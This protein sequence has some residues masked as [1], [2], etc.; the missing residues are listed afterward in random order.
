MKKFT[1]SRLRTKFTISSLTIIVLLGTFW[2]GDTLHGQ[3]YN[4]FTPHST[5]RVDFSALN[6][7]YALMK[8]NF[9][10]KIDAKSALE[11]ATHYPVPAVIEQSFQALWEKQRD[12]LLASL[13]ARRVERT[14]NLEKSL[15]ELAEKEVNKL[16]TVMLELQRSIQDELER[17]DGPQMLLDLGGDETGK[18]QCQRD[19]DALRRRVKE[20]PEEIER[21]SNHIRSRFANPSARLFPVAVTWLIPRK[22]VLEITGGKL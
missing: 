20:I 22:A 19:M 1:S 7:I 2:A 15:E 21:E 4:P 17:K 18:Q 13:E 8:N 16:R 5:D 6:E 10:G 14:K 9:D 11:A 3:F 12:G